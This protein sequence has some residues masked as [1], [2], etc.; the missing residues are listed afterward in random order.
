MEVGDCW[1]R[2][3][4]EGCRVKM[5]SEEPRCRIYNED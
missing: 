2:K 5:K 3:N 1:W 4:D